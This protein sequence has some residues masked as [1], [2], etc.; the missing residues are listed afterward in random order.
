[1]QRLSTEQV[2]VAA[3]WWAEALCAPKF[4]N[5]DNARPGG[6]ISGMAASLIAPV[7]EHQ[8]AVFRDALV[9]ILTGATEHILGF[10]GLGV[11]YDPDEWLS[12]A[13]DLARI[14]H[15]NAPWK[16]KLWFENGG[17]TAHTP[18]GLQV[19]LAPTAENERPL[20]VPSG[21]PSQTEPV[22]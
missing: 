15:F 13:M 8:R 21:V 4:D 3:D 16:T 11:D 9:S 5:G 6:F 19:L 14:S 1:M 2:K 12:P 18:N 22:T 17:V 7:T 10:R 20:V